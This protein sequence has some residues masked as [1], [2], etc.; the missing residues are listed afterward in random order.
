MRL[1][2]W[3]PSWIY[4]DGPLLFSIAYRPTTLAAVL[5][6]PLLSREAQRPF[7]DRKEE[8]YM[9]SEV[10]NTNAVIA[11][12]KATTRV[13]LLSLFIALVFAMTIS[14]AK[15]HAQIV[16]NIQVNVPFQFHAGDTKLPAGKYVIH[17]LENSDLNVMEISSA[18][19]STSA[20]LQVREAET[21]STPA[22]SELIFNKVGNQYF[23]A[24]VFD[25]GNT[26]GSEIISNRDE[27]TVNQASDNDQEH[28]Q[29]QS[30]AQKGN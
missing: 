27:K 12:R 20:L 30:L 1:A 5:H 10:I 29:A 3:H 13:H 22:K 18:D 23:L 8:S 21:N 11:G 25:E 9:S 26:S 19:G 15:A 16:G 17:M 7:V 2:Y 24:R 6:S 14:P 4:I 28:V